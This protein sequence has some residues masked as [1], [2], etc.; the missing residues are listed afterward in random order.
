[1][2]ALLVEVELLRDDR[3]A[4][5]KAFEQ[6]RSLEER[7]ESNEIRAHMRLASAELD[8]QAGDLDG[9]VE[10]LETALMLLIHY[11]RPLLRARSDW[12]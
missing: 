10:Q 6:L 11:D 12:N 5:E 9:A 1:V 4:A 3:P 2:L 7:C 8:R